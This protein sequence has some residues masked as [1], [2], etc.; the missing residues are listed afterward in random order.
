MEQCLSLV[1]EHSDKSAALDVG[2][3][4]IDKRHFMT[5]FDAD[6]RLHCDAALSAVSRLN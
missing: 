1:V 4:G 2:S 6:H 5:G 3:T